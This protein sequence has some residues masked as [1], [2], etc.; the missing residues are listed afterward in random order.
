MT[1]SEFTLAEQGFSDL[2]IIPRE[3]WFQVSPTA[4]ESWSDINEIIKDKAATA[5]RSADV[6][7]SFSEAPISQTAI[8][9]LGLL[10]TR[11]GWRVIL[12]TTN[13]ES[14]SNISPSGSE[15][16]TNVTPSGT[17]TWKN[18]L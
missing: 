15:S 18:I 17:E 14:W 6:A 3:F 12:N 1:F 7:S 16:W 4:N 10:V 13:I 2:N 9:D 8:S 5:L 11:E